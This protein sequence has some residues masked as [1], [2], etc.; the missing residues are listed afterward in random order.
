MCK[1]SGHESSVQGQVILSPGGWQKY[2]LY[3]HFFRSTGEASNTDAL[4]WRGEG[5]VRGKEQGGVSRVGLYSRTAE[6]LAVIPC[7][8]GP[9]ENVQDWFVPCLWWPWLGITLLC[10][11]LVSLLWAVWPGVGLAVAEGRCVSQV[12]AG[13]GLL[14]WECCQ[15]PG[16]GPQQKGSEKGGRA[17]SISDFAQD[18]WF[19]AYS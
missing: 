13:E 5:R 14:A 15:G 19:A 10:P 11:C 8:L 18:T 9:A 12:P 3:S 2:M 4:W 1:L 16:H 7:D 6:L 17:A